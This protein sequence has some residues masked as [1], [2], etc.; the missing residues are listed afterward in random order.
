MTPREWRVQSSIG[1]LQKDNRW[2]PTSLGMPSLVVVLIMTALELSYA[3]QVSIGV[4]WSEYLFSAFCYSFNMC[5]ASR[6]RTKLSNSELQVAGDQWPIFLYAN[7]TYN[8]EDPWNGLLCSGLLV[9]VSF[10]DEWSGFSC[11]PILPTEGIQTCLHIP[12][13]HRSG[14]QGNTFWACPYPWDA[15]DYKGIPCLC[16]YTGTGKGDF[17]LFLTHFSVGLLCIDFGSSIFSHWPCHRF[18]TLLQ[19]Y[20]GVTGWSGGKGWSRPTDGMVESVSHL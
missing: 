6:T 19:F 9:S 17:C 2:P 10:N 13:L 12:E 4:T 15:L 5:V 8:P 11:W 16:R 7:Y 1:L 18:R 14:T 20:S 3:P